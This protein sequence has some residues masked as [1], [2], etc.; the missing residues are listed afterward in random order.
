MNA[1]F[2]A[3]AAYLLGGIPT[4]VAVSKHLLGRD[5][6]DFGS[7]NPGA[8]NVWRVFGLKWGLFVVA[9]DIGK[10]YLAVKLLPQLAGE[11]AWPGFAS[12]L[13][14]M[15]VAGHIWSPFTRFRGGKGV[16]TAAGAA[17]AL[18]PSAALTAIAVWVLVASITRYASVAAMTAAC[19]YPAA[20]FWIND[21]TRGQIVAALIIPTIVFWTHRENLHRLKDGN[22]LKIGGRRIAG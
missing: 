10:G 19:L 13:G 2:S 3:F 11:S 16:G 8:V 18:H 9:V 22:E 15:A 12:F 6:R 7:G 21:A 4:G 20:V 5:V 14:L 17:L 1:L